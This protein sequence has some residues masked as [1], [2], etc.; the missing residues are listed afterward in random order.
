MRIGIIGMGFVGK[1]VAAANSNSDII[2][3][4][5]AYVGSKLISEFSNCDGIYVCVPSPMNETTGECDSSI[6]N[7]TLVALSANITTANCPIICK[8]TAPPSIYASLQLM[9]P[10]IVH[11]PEFL[12]AANSVNDYATRSKTILGGHPVWCEKAKTVIL[13]QDLKSHEYILTDIK[14]AALYKYMMNS[15]LATK[16]TFMNEF[17]LLADALDVSWDNITT[18][19]ISDNRIGNSHMQVPGPDGKYGWEG[20]CFPKDISAIIVEAQKCAVSMHVLDTVQKT[21][22]QHRKINEN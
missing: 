11:F 12:T 22:N 15:Y 16:V 17:K 19:A 3:H 13:N 18:C 7:S 1:A 4:D 14:S 5:P 9:Y 10:N 21:N 20:A 8:T 2:V 6:L